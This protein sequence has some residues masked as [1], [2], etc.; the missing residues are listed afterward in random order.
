M[1]F[2]FL[3]GN[4]CSFGDC[5]SAVPASNATAATS[6]NATTCACEPGWTGKADLKWASVQSNSGLLLAFVQKTFI[7]WGHTL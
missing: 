2:S 1:K 7:H 3:P 5:V 6:S 4:P